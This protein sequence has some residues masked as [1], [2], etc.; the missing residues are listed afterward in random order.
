MTPLVVAII[1]VF[2]TAA[3]FGITT[4][5]GIQLGSFTTVSSYAGS[6]NSGPDPDAVNFG[7]QYG[8]AGGNFNNQRH[9]SVQQLTNECI[10]KGNQFSRRGKSLLLLLIWGSKKIFLVM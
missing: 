8:Q 9:R 2:F 6:R 1:A 7:Q 5:N 3:C 10:E 4:K